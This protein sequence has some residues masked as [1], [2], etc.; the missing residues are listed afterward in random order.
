MVIFQVFLLALACIFTAKTAVTAFDFRNA[1]T[2]D[3]TLLRATA[4]EFVASAISL[5]LVVV[6]FLHFTKP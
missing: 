6:T 2:Q 3:V 1:R 5:L 4:T